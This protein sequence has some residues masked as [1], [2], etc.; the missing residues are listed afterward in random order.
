MNGVRELWV[1]RS[2]ELAKRAGF[3]GPYHRHVQDNDKVAWWPG[4][5][6]DIV[7]GVVL[8]Q[9]VITDEFQRWLHYANASE[10]HDAGYVL[11]LIRTRLCVEPGIWIDL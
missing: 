9:V 3:R 6:V 11:E 10:R 2:Q 8:G 5:D 7:R 4:R 1:F